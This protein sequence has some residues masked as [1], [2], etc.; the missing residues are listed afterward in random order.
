MH[1]SNRTST[2]D[3]S[4]SRIMMLSIVGVD[5]PGITSTVADILSQYSA[6]VLDIGQ[7]VIHS[8]LNLGMLI[9]LAPSTNLD[10]LKNEISVALHALDNRVVFESIPLKSYTQWAA[11]QDKPR[12]IV[13]LLA[14][15]VNATHIAALMQVA[16]AHGLNVDYIKR[17]SGP[18]GLA[19]TSRQTKS[20]IE[21]SAQG[22]P[23]DIAALR[24]AFMALTAEHDI[25]IAVQEESI[26]RRNR[27]LVCF[28][29]DSTL[30][31]TE[32][33]N[34]LALEAG[35]GEQVAAITEAAM[36][37]EIDFNQSFSQRMALLKGLDASVLAAVAARLPLTEGVEHLFKVLN[38]LGYKTAILSGGFD[39][40]ARYLQAKL[41]INYIYANTLDIEQGQLTGKVV[42]NVVNGE[43]KAALLQE[44]A[45]REKISLQQ[46]VAVGDGANDLPML[47]LAG[48]GIAFRAK[49]LVKTSAE[50][51]ISQLGLDAILYLMGLSDRD[52]AC[53][54]SP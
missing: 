29:M 12:H 31:E 16:F 44:L 41:G 18:I 43:R 45:A 20:S 3:T 1:A 32:V 52:M 6:S 53:L 30:I 49:P 40:F 24:R 17:L 19:A 54:N 28:D 2:T 7:A 13:T 33:I 22:R 39:Y 27:R 37:G 14:R 10:A 46:V 15:Q 36:S 38:H 11:Q 50:Q 25:D 47:S 51:S 26:F 34:E 42:G 35:V 9:S 8:Y 48:L 4:P 5:Q 23:G 21:F